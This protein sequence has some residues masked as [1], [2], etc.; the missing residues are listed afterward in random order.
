ML[1]LR[2]AYRS[3]RGPR[4]CG[5]RARRLLTLVMLFVFGLSVW[6]AP[7]A[8]ARFP[9][10]DSMASQPS[11]MPHLDGCDDDC[12]GPMPMR[13]PAPC[14]LLC[15]MLPVRTAADLQGEPLQA[16]WDGPMADLRTGRELE[17]DDPPPRV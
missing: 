4:G 1:I 13:C 9:L 14:A 3:K 15:L 2:G 11:M 6:S 7:V 12:C 10:D 5:F 17:V 8:S 16:E